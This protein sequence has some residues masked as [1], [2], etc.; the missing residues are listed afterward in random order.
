MRMESKQ[1]SNSINYL[2]KNY[3]KKNKDKIKNKKRS[4]GIDLK[5]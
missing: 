5:N 3:N 1:K 2:L 4:L